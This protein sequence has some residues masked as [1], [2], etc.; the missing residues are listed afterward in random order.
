M[1][2]H[3]ALTETASQLV[4]YIS[5]RTA[6][7]VDRYR[8]FARKSAES[9]IEMAITIVEAEE[10]LNQDEQREFFSQIRVEQGSSYYKKLRVI[11]KNSPRFTSHLQRLPSAWTTLYK[12]A[13]LVPDQFEHLVQS[14]VLSP[15]VTAEQIDDA[16]GCIERARPARNAPRPK[17]SKEKSKSEFN[18]FFDIVSASD[19]C[20]CELD[21]TFDALASNFDMRIETREDINKLMKIARKRVQQRASS[22][23]QETK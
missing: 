23:A 10:T 13:S 20:L 21:D 15:Q 14:D 3:I 4:T 2:H 16:L 18:V 7:L 1:I 9:I 8:T 19:E 11:A 5:P 12:L 6:A 17:A 22:V